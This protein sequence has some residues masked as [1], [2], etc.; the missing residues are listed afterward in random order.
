MADAIENRRF[1]GVARVY[2]QA[3]MDKLRTSHVAIAGIG[4]V[5]TW[6]AEALARSA[7]G[8]LTLIDLDHIAESN[9]NRQLHA[10]NSTLGQAKVQA[11]AARIREINPDARLHCVEDFVS[12]DNIEALLTD[13]PDVLIDATDDAKAKIAMAVWS[14]AHGIPLVMSGAAG[15]RRNPTRIELADL[16]QAH[17]DRLLSKT[18]QQLRKLHGFPSTLGKHF[19]ISVVYSAEMVSKPD[20]TCA[21]I[22]GGL[23]CAGY[24]SSVCVTAGFGM[25]AAAHA[26]ELICK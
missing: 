11:M 4:G 16:A 21:P 14:R 7:V 5:G 2:G 6:V 17:G 10:L 23:H 25:V 8:T 15:G 26:I 24:G 13:R 18:R 1:N 22:S 9:I 3:G 12:Q 19:G 20:T